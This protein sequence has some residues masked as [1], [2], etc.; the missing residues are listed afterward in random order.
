MPGPGL[1]EVTPG[2]GDTRS[3]ALS[4]L[5]SPWSSQAGVMCYG[6]CVACHSSCFHNDIGSPQSPAHTCRNSFQKYQ[7]SYRLIDGKG[8]ATVLQ[9]TKGKEG[10]PVVV[11]T[12]VLDLE[13]SFV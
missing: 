4:C 3:S 1:E 7:G 11:S 13:H 12:E 2:G 10:R 5:H 9:W 6:F 8:R